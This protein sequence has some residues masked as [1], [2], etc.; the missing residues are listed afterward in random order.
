MDVKAVLKLEGA[1]V[2]LAAVWVYAMSGQSWWLFAALVLLPD[3]FM[4]GYLVNN[5]VGAA[6]YNLGHTYCVPIAVLLV[7]LQFAVPVLSA[8]ATIWI[9]HIGMDRM[10][11]Y[12]LK[13]VDGFKVTH[14]SRP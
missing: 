12:G 2:A 1:A 3:L 10:L 7:G 9:A 5:R 8:I 11:G 13:R 6:L 14:L 4:V